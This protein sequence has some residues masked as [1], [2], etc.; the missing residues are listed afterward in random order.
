MS[1]DDERLLDI[2]KNVSEEKNAEKLTAL[3]SELNHELQRQRV[4]RESEA[5]QP[6]PDVEQRLAS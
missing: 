1:R 2:C 6:E 4:K 5:L 3:I